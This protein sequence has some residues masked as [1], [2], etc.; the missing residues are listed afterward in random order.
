M[1]SLITSNI[2]FQRKTLNRVAALVIGMLPML[3]SC[4]TIHFSRQNTDI[5]WNMR[6]TLSDRPG[7]YAIVGRA[8]L[9]DRTPLT[10]IALRYLHPGQANQEVN[11]HPTYSILAYNPTEVM[12]GQWQTNLNLWQVGPD[13]RYQ[14][15]WQLEQRHLDLALNPD[16]E[17]IFLTTLAPVSALPKVEQTLGNQ[18]R[19]LPQRSLYTTGEGE[20]FAQVNQ[21]IEV[22]LP[23]GSTTPAIPSLDDR[24]DG[25]GERYLIPK[26]P[27][28]PTRLTRP[29]NRQT[30]APPRTVEF[31]H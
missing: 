1:W 3:S 27:Q 26:E 23:T 21:S 8:D 4:E 24:N 30:N 15:A 25:W 12:K 29:D 9:P 11:P 10:V 14:E 7:Q 20:R 18:G 6:V 5:D 19:Q 28:N 16:A 2:I 13:G 22:A 17:V 31:L